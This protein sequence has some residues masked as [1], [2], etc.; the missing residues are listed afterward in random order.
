MPKRSVIAVISAVAIA[1]MSTVVLLPGTAGAQASPPAP[2]NF[3]TSSMRVLAGSQVSLHWST[4][5]DYFFLLTSAATDSLP[6]FSASSVVQW[7]SGANATWNSAWGWWQT[8]NSETV[9]ITIPAN[10]TGG[11]QYAFQLYTCDS[12]TDLCSNSSGSS[13][14]GDS[15]ATMT[16]AGS[17]WSQVPYTNH[18]KYLVMNTQSSGGPTDS[19]FSTSNKL[20]VESEFLD[21]L[22]EVA[23]TKPSTP[24]STKASTAINDPYNLDKDPFVTCL[25]STCSNTDWSEL[26]ESSIY[27]GKMV[28]A[29]EG[30]WT[31]YSG[32]L[33]NNSEVVAYD[34]TTDGY[35][36][37][38]V[39]GNND[40]VYGITASG[41][42]KDTTIWFDAQDTTG[43]EPVLE[44]FKP[45][46]VGDTCPR[47]YNLNG[48]SSFQ[49][50]AL[51]NN[52]PTEIAA[53]PTGS[54]IWVGDVF[55][56]DIESV[57][58]TTG[59]VTSYDYTPT[60]AYSTFPYPSTPT[61]YSWQVV[62]DA[63][64]VYASDFGDANLVRIQT[65]APNPGEI[66]EVPLPVN[67][68]QERGFGLALD[69]DTLYFTTT[70]GGTLGYI[71]IGAWEAASSACS[72]GD[73]CAPT[74]ADA[75]EYTGIEE[76]TDP[77]T[78]GYS[79]AGSGSYGGISV[80]STG[81]VAMSDY[82]SKQTIRLVPRR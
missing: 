31:T 1:V 7:P 73:D 39:P 60:N 8:S 47:T 44:S 10:A 30:G 37:Y 11:T 43:G 38:I 75:V 77:S 81:Q 80:S 52:W 14:P 5:T 16:V 66:D 68:D 28:W 49:E 41:S 51:P 13:G 46:V 4:E 17:N 57:N 71:N 79:P 22:G 54:E 33:Q 23:Y 76:Q 62:A 50:F 15:E 63:D 3:G 21:G 55:G 29:T 74:P 24:V 19:A 42:G 65:S 82:F 9:T 40:T 32:S 69:G 58:T 67:S 36:T 26:G 12:Q 78:D 48:A 72:P 64:Y 2:E 18:F 20:W 70:N 25:S 59:A 56:N 61:A 6:N 34:P 27:A 45:K 53:N 35:C